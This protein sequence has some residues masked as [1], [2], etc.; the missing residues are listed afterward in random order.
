MEK[1]YAWRNIRIMRWYLALAEPLFWGPVLVLYFSEVAGMSLDE[2]YFMEAVVLLGGAV[3]EVLTGSLADHIGRKKTIVIGRALFI[4]YVAGF[5]IADSPLDVWIANITWVVGYAFVSGADQALF[6]DSLKLL[7]KESAFQREWGKGVARRLAI[8]AVT[9]LA[10]GLLYKVHP[11][12]P[13]LISIPGIIGAFVLTL[14]L[15]EPPRSKLYKLRDQL[16]IL[17]EGILVVV[18]RPKVRWIVLYAA[19]IGVAMKGWFFLYN[20]YFEVV[21]LPLVWYGLVFSALNIVAA[22]ASRL[23]HRISARLGEY[24]SIWFIAIGAGLL[25]FIMGAYPAQGAVSLIVLS[26]IMR[27]FYPIFTSSF[28]HRWVSSNIRATVKSIEGSVRAVVEFIM[29]GCLSLVSANV[30]VSATLMVLGGF[31]LA[32]SM[33]HI[34]RYRKIFRP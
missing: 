9:C 11:R 20:P 10:V 3:L 21:E 26:N 19:V 22:F 27:G 29:L 4:L 17:K 12:L 13:I 15:W 1:H 2:M 24:W 34:A 32:F 5:A 16:D 30:S 31:T 23:S 14:F 25:M 8:S 33:R 28:L 18:R 7:G 6:Y